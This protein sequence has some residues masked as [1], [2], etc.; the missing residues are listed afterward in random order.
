MLKR[1]SV[2]AIGIGFLNL[3]L[4]RRGKNECLFVFFIVK[5]EKKES[6]EL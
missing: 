5:A 3:I 4:K 6:N 1:L 2:V